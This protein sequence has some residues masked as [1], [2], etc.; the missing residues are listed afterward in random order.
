MVSFTHPTRQPTTIS[1]RPLLIL[2]FAADYAVGKLHVEI[3]HFTNLLIH[4]MAA[5]LLYAIVRGTLLIQTPTGSATWLA[6]TI[7]VLWVAHPLNTQAVTY[8]VQRAESLASLFLLASLYCVIRSASGGKGWGA[9]AIIACTMGMATKEIGAA[10]PIIA[11]L[12]DR[13]FLSG[14][15][16]EAIRMRGKIYAGMAATWVLILLSLYTGRRGSMVGFH[17]GISMLDYARTELNVI[18]LYLRLAFWPGN[19]V[20]DYYDWPIA[21]HWAEISWQGWGMLALVLGTLLAMRY[22]PRRGFL[23]A[24]FFLILAPT[25][26]FL[27]IKQ[28]AAAEQRMYLPL[29]AVICLVVIGGWTV[30]RRWRILR[31]MGAAAVCVAVIELIHLTMARNEQYANAVDIWTDTV[32]KRPD[33]TR[34]RH[35]LGE[36]WAQASLDFPPGTADAVAAV[37]QGQAQFQI[38]LESE[39]H[40]TEAVFEIGQSL[41]RMGDLSAAEDFYTRAINK[42]P[43]VAGDLLL[44]R[45]NLRARREDWPDAKSDFLAAIAANPGNVEPHYFLGVL[46]QQT[47]NWADAKK[48]LAKAVE[49]SPKYKDAANRL[50]A[51]EKSSGE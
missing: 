18:A 5:L 22:K 20:L 42:Y 31:W 9:A 49:I 39:P 23:V 7:V 14:S 41:E 13:A 33:N 34:A 45:G 35:N 24:C 8:V 26:S 17:L 40:L 28:E 29:A 11:I 19:L 3:Y 4:L 27:P 12:Y 37:R 15:F 51:V 38:V 46:Y 1:G 16:R 48:E 50:K 47:G 25:S 6:A 2:S 21:R 36:A 30:V 44:E 43:D 32:T 10:A